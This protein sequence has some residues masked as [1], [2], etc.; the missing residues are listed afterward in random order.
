MEED[1]AFDPAD[2]GPLGADEVVFEADDVTDSIEQ[3]FW[4]LVPSLF[5]SGTV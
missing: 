1:V 2:V 3:F 5:P 4:K